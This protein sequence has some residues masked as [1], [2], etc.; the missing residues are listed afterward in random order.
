[1]M[2][3]IVIPLYNKARFIK[4]SLDSIFQ[5]TVGDYEIIVVDDGST[6]GSPDL[7][8]EYDDG[9]I[10]L[11]RQKNSGVSAARNRGI[12]ESIGNWIAF[13][14]AD[15]AWKPHYLHTVSTLIDKFSQAGAYSTAYEII[16]ATGR[17][18]R[19][20]YEA[21]PPTP[22]N[23][24]IPSYFRS[25]LGQPPVWTSATTVPK[26]V[27]QKVGYFPVGV[28]LGED[29]DMWGRIALKYDIAFSNRISSIYFREDLGRPQKE[30]YYVRNPIAPFVKTARAAIAQGN[31]SA[32]NLDE[33]LE[34]LERIQIGVGCECLL[35]GHNPAAAR[36]IILETHPRTYRFK[37][38]KYR[39]LIQTFLPD[40][41][42]RLT[43]RMM[44]IL[45]GQY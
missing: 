17:I 45:K 15:D 16:L 26:T 37:L 43:I 11:I 3:S 23:G 41:L 42:V 24:I 34:Y 39:A 29:I 5:Q 12:E 30:H 33:L 44:A 8:K 27:F 28:S 21:I 10:K 6:D 32:V 18:M 20:K 4:R 35:D 25:A 9:R 19:P 7:V 22:W 36:K 2:F 31:I 40:E 14:D 13:L 38:K 1:M